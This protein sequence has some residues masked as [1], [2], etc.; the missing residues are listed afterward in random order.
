[1]PTICV[2]HIDDETGLL[3]GAKIFGIDDHHA[4]FITQSDQRDNFYLALGPSGSPADAVI[5]MNIEQLRSL[6]DAATKLL[7]QLLDFPGEHPLKAARARVEKQ[8]I[9][10]HSYLSA[11]DN[12][13]A[14][15]DRAYRGCSREING[16]ICGRSRKEHAK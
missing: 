1:M 16:S 6:R 13:R 8:L 9:K 12:P 4:L 7:D 3:S 11:G 14:S 5:T 10:D 15:G 2:K